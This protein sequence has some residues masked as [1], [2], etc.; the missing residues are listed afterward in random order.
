[1]N[2]SHYRCLPEKVESCCIKTKTTP[3]SLSPKSK[4]SDISLFE[5]Q[6]KGCSTLHYHKTKHTLFIIEGEGAIFDG[7]KLMPIHPD[8]VITI[9]PNESHQIRNIGK[10][11]LKYL[12]I[13]S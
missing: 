7:E 9:L 5:M 6:P 13:S 8:D 2:I 4:K 3:L 10:K 1:M 11:L 12:S